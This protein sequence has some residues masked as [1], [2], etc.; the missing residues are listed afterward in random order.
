MECA[1][2][3]NVTGRVGNNDAS[4]AVENGAAVARQP[5]GAA[6]QGGRKGPARKGGPTSADANVRG[7]A[8]AINWVLGAR[9][10][11][12]NPGVSA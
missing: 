10:A 2:A 4:E 1:V 12:S 5:A 7:M 6:L 11:G 9:G 3:A 8:I